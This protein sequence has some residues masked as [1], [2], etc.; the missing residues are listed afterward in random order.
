MKK[1]INGKTYNT[2][3]AIEIAH[4][5][6]VDGFNSESTTLYQTKNGAFFIAGNGGPMTRWAERGKTGGWNNGAGIHVFS[7]EQALSFAENNIYDIDN[8]SKYFE[9]VEA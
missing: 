7:V 9:I 1:T 8:L 3:T 4:Y 6:S 5:S 2:E